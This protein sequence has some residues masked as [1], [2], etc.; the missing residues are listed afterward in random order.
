MSESRPPGVRRGAL[1]LAEV[2]V[3]AQGDLHAGRVNDAVRLIFGFCDD[4]RGSDREGQAYL[5]RDEPP[6][7]EHQGYNAALAGTAEFFADEAGLDPP[8]WAE[9]PARFASPWWFVADDPVFHAYVLARTPGAY[10]RHGVF[11]AREVFDRV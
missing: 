5:L 9:G 6:L 11:M 2:A 3:E 7:A 4:F 8:A 1:T 10:L